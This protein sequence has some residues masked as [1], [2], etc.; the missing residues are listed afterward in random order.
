MSKLRVNAF[1]ISI[2]GYGAGPDQSLQNPMGVGGMA[3]HEWVFGTKTFQKVAGE[4][5][6][7]AASTCSPVLTRSGVA[8]NALS[9]RSRNA[10]RMWSWQSEEYTRMERH[11]LVEQRFPPRGTR[12]PGISHGRALPSGFLAPVNLYNDVNP[13]HLETVRGLRRHNADSTDL[14]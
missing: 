12:I 6:W 11:C 3:L 10:P 7:A 5:S 9:T 14:S 1:G 2:D 8:T 13:R 4:S